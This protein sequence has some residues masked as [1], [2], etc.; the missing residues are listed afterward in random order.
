MGA[1]APYLERRKMDCWHCNAELIWG[2]DHDYE[3]YGLEGGGIVSNLSCSKC[4]AS[5][6]VYLPL[7]NDKEDDEGSE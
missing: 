7:S 4:E 1:A 5:V 3:D 6:E 2:G